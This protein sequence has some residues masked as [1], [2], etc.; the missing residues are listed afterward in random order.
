VKFTLCLIKQQAYESYGGVQ[1]KLCTFLISALNGFH[2]SL[3]VATAL[4]PNNE[5]PTQIWQGAG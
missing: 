5:P 2:R 4:L 1:M 3:R